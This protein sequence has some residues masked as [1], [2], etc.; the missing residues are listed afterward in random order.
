MTAPCQITS[1]PFQQSAIKPT[2]ATSIIQQS[3]PIACASQ[4]MGKMMADRPKTNRIFAMF[5]P[6]TLPTAI[7]GVPLITASRLTTNSGDEVPKATIV[8][9]ITRGGTDSSC[10]SATAPRTRDSAPIRS[11]TR[12][13]A[14]I[15]YV[16]YRV[17]RRLPR[18][19]SGTATHRVW[20]IYI[21]MSGSRLK[22]CLYFGCPEGF[23]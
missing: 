3:R 10:A 15:R 11:N 23:G 5:D 22:R 2:V 4:A 14:T 9:P 16:I 20:N 19:G 21:Y 12:P 13:L 7:C 6:T 17:H 8:S 1:C 18:V